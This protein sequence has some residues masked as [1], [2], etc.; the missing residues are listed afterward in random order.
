MGEL[1]LI[2]GAPQSKPLQLQAG[3]K[4][5]FR[6]INITNNN[7]GL[8]VSLRSANGPVD[9]WVIAKDGADLPASLVHQSKAQMTITVGETYDVEFASD[10]PQDPPYGLR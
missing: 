2:N 6:L 10:V 7:Q 4:Y 9:W 1:V 3:K 5:R 8:Q